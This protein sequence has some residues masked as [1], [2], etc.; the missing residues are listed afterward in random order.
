MQAQEILTDYQ[1]LRSDMPEANLLALEA[2]TYHLNVETKTLTTVEAVYAALDSFNPISGWIGY[3]SGNQYFVNESL[4][5]KSDYGVLLNAEMTNGSG[6]S[7]HVRYN[8][9][10]SWVVTQ[11]HY[12]KGEEYVADT[13]KHLASFD[14][15]GNTTLRYLRFW[16]VQ[17]GSLGV[18]PVFACFVGFGG[19]A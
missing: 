8:G 19:K 7:L 3:Q 10:G 17:D 14:K 9:S 12:G 13:V 4:A 5:F 16:K 6:V 11:Y 15:D 18:N 1:K 2:M